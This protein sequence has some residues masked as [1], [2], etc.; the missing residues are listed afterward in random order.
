MTGDFSLYRFFNIKRLQWE[1]DHQ[2]QLG[3]HKQAA[4]DF[5]PFA[6][7]ARGVSESWEDIRN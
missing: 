4:V 5:P 7:A 1:R 2:Q 3:R 6:L